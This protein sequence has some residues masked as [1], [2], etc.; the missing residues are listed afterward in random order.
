[1]TLVFYNRVLFTHLVLLTLGGFMYENNNQGYC[2]ERTV[3]FLPKF[4]E[5]KGEEDYD[6]VLNKVIGDEKE[7]LIEIGSLE[8]EDQEEEKEE[9]IKKK[10][11]GSDNY[12]NNLALKLY[13]QIQGTNF[14]FSPF[15]IV[16][17][18]SLVQMGSQGDTSK[19]L[20]NVLGLKDSEED[21]FY[22]SLSKKNKA[23]IQAT[24]GSFYS[25]NYM[26]LKKDTSHV[27][28]RKY[29]KKIKSLYDLTPNVFDESNGKKIV[30]S[31]NEEIKKDTQ[32]K[33]KSF[34]TPKDIQS[35]ILIVINVVLMKGN[36]LTQF[37]ERKTQEKTLFFR[38]SG[39]TPVQ[40]MLQKSNFKYVELPQIEAKALKMGFKQGNLSMVFV[41]PDRIFGLPDLMKELSLL[42]LNEIFETLNESKAVFVE[43]HLPKFKCNSTF[44]M[45]TILEKLG[46]NQIFSSSLADLKGIL[47]P[48]NGDNLYVTDLSQRVEIEVDEKGSRAVGASKM[49][50]SVFRNYSK[51]RK[52]I[53]N[54]NHG[55]MFAIIDDQT[56]DIIFMGNYGGGEETGKKVERANSL[57]TV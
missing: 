11:L 2:D 16:M 21:L 4:I 10:P 31:V 29:L 42:I 38:P 7:D 20:R 24:T 5:K 25:N 8:E 40:M 13:K 30:K 56:H 49:K 50:A 3:E 53:F 51:R 57:R 41:L 28:N 39:C 32:G 47:S 19:E 9:E 54:M 27:I 23:L 14:I 33:I 34:L 1:M 6:A 48:S 46:V 55:F 43:V 15:S 36:W 44:D 52:R 35:A 26:L 45:K 37:K 18:L 17:A 12:V 22:I